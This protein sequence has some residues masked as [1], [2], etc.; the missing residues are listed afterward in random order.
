M[1]KSKKV[2]EQNNQLWKLRSKHGRDKLFKTPDL[3]M[4]AATEYFQY[5]NT[6]PILKEDYVGGFATRVFRELPRPYTLAGLCIYVG[7]SRSWWNEF[8]KTAN[9]DFLEVIS[10]IDE[11]IYN[12]KFE[13]ATAGVFNANIISRDLGLVDKKDMT[14]DGEPIS[15]KRPATKLPDGT[16]L[17]I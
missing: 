6:T 3:L 15:D 8:K 16:Y 4:E 7:A 14:T 10:L 2:F 11:M 12:Q 9:A 5:C 1:A 13:G 17:E